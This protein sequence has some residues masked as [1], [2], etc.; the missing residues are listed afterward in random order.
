M[1]GWGGSYQL[2]IAT[3]S[4]VAALQREAHGEIW[5]DTEWGEIRRTERNERNERN[6]RKEREKREH[7]ENRENRERRRI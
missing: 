1:G 2:F 4:H 5:R 3:L 6:E 7:R